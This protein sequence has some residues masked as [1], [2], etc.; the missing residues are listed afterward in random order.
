LG[1]ALGPLL[2]GW[3]CDITG[4]YDLAFLIFSILSFISVIVAYFLKPV[5]GGRK[6]ESTGS[7]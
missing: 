5:G 1:G 7:A 3:L 2:A 4:N 6:N